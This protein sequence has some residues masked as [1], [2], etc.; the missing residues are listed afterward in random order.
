MVMIAA[1]I[2]LS[3]GLVVTLTVWV[4][5]SARE[6]VDTMSRT[7]ENLLTLARGSC[8]LRYRRHRQAQRHERADGEKCAAFHRLTPHSRSTCRTCA[9]SG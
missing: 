7:V 4:G 6:E 2:E 5:W 3:L 9:R 1:T 8:V